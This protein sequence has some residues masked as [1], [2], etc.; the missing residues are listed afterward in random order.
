[1]LA[2][3]FV[4][5]W[6]GDQTID[7]K[8]LLGVIVYNAFF[9]VMMPEIDWRAHAGGFATGLILGGI[10]QLVALFRGGDAA[11]LIAT[12]KKEVRADA[13]GEE[14]V[15]RALEAPAT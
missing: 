5:R 12:P 13:I 9:A 15:R 3:L 6:A 11:T 4:L 2:E 1:V 7:A 10:L 14:A 8:D